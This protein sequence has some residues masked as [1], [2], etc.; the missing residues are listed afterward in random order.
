MREKLRRCRRC[1]QMGFGV[2]RVTGFVC[3]ACRVEERG[4]AIHTPHRPRRL[5]GSWADVYY[6]DH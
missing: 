1:R 4:R 5:T 6:R 3:E 2:C